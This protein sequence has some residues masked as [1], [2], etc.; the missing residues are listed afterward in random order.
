MVHA[1]SCMPNVCDNNVYEAQTCT[2]FYYL[3]VLISV[4]D[5]GTVEVLHKGYELPDPRGSLANGRYIFLSYRTGQSRGSTR[6]TVIKPSIKHIVIS[7]FLNSV[8]YLIS[9]TRL[10]IKLNLFE[11]YFYIY[12]NESFQIY[13]ICG[14]CMVLG[15]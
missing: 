11:F 13:S 1:H 14:A 9:Y 7:I 2:L 3:I 5:D 6:P 4:Q 15:C 8:C 12:Y 10:F